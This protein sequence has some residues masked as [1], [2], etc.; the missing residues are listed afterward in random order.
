MSWF[1]METETLFHAHERKCGADKHITK[2][3]KITFSAQDLN[4]H[5]LCKSD[6]S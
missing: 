5:F 2:R 1:K 4:P 3:R 6:F